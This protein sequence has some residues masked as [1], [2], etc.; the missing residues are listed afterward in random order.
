MRLSEILKPSSVRVAAESRDKKSIIREL[1]GLAAPDAA[2]VEQVFAAVMERENIKTTGIGHSLATPHAKTPA[3][4]KLVM[5]LAV[6]K[7][8]ID[9]DSLDGRPVSVVILL[10]APPDQTGPYIQAL[11]RISKLM[12]IESLRRRILE[13]AGGDEVFKILVEEEAHLLKC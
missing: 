2:N 9:F 1:V 3:V 10:L 7:T 12:S 4:K 8:P 5:A 13:A 6:A 11:A